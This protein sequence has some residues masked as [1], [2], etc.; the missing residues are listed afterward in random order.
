MR[1]RFK[2]KKAAVL[3][4]LTREGR[5]EREKREREAGTAPG[6]DGGRPRPPAAEVLLPECN[7]V[8][9]CTPYMGTSGSFLGAGLAGMRAHSPVPPNKQNKTNIQYASCQLDLFHK[10]PLLS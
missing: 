6:C 4:H 2:G 1:G 5:A 3:G 7:M 8:P 10:T 9:F